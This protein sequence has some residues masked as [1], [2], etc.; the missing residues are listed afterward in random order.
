MFKVNPGTQFVRDD[1][2]LYFQGTCD[3]T[4]DLPSTVDGF[5]PSFGSLILV[6]PAGNFYYFNG[7]TWTKVGS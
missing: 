4:G 2:T 3:T 1:G 7:S 5:E 6:G